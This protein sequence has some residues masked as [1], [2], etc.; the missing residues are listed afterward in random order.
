MH[1]VVGIDPLLMYLVELFA[2]LSG[3]EQYSEYSGYAE[4]FKWKDN[5]KDKIPR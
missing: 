2:V 5:H 3:T 1:T 4:S